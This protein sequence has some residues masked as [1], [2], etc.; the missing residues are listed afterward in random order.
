MAVL[1][2]SNPHQRRSSMIAAAMTEGIRAAGDK[3][4]AKP[5][6]AAVVVSYGW[7]RQEIYRQYPAFVYADL[8][9]WDRDNY[10]RFAVNSWGPESYVCGGHP[11]NRFQR[12]GLKIKPW[13]MA[14]SE[15]VVAGHSFKSARDHG[16]EYQ[17]WESRVIERLQGCGFPIVYRPKPGDKHAKPIPGTQMDQ[18]PIG[19]ALASARA[20]VTHHSN[21]A[22]DAL[23]AG[24][25]VHCETGAAAAFSVSLDEIVN[26]PMRQGRE[27][28]LHDVAWLQWTF[29]EMRSGECWRHLR[30][31]L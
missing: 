30:T 29:D 2:L 14:G 23:V 7:K 9:Y 31:L 10:H 11:A 5:R 1:V 16:L 13:N 22:V 28:F 15:I 26:P 25:P 19:E 4:T 21:S 18:R 8:G 27:Q 6:K 12:L 24:V 17:A 3:I 20:W